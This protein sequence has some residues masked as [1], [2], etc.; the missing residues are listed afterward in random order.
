MNKQNVLYSYNG[1]LFGNK[2][3]RNIDL[4]QHGWI[5]GI[6]EASCK[7]LHTV[8]FRLYKISRNRNLQKKAYH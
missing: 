1:I 8:W 7:R 5:S 2:K 3:G 6:L 4:L